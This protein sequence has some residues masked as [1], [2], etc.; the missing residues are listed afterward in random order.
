MPVYVRVF[1]VCDSTSLCSLEF[2]I[3]IHFLVEV[4]EGG[5]EGEAAIQAARDA[6]V[7]LHLR[8]RITQM[9]IREQ[10]RNKTLPQCPSCQLHVQTGQKY[11]TQ[12]DE[13][14]HSGCFNCIH[15]SK[16]LEGL[17]HVFVDGNYWCTTHWKAVLK[18]SEG[19]QQKY[20]R[21]CNCLFVLRLCVCLHFAVDR[22][23]TKACEA[24]GRSAGKVH[25]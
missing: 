2:T 3:F 5:G 8:A 20:V 23:S 11:V 24:E 10:L 9:R 18:S 6:R 14:L 19:M 16:E 17:E 21:V 12:G 25:R 22:C 4:I 15:C 7:E 1:R 13:M